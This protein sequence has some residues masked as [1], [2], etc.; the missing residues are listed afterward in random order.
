MAMHRSSS[1]AGSNPRRRAPP[2]AAPAPTAGAG[3]RGRP[4]A[5]HAPGA[6]RVRGQPQHSAALPGR[7][8]RWRHR[9]GARAVDRRTRVGRR[10]PA[11]AAELWAGAGTGPSPQVWA[12]ARACAT[13]ALLACCRRTRCWRVVLQCAAHSR[14]RL[15]ISG[16]PRRTQCTTLL[17]TCSAPTRRPTAPTSPP[18]PTA[19][20]CCWCAPCLACRCFARLPDPAAGA[21]RCMPLH[22]RYSCPHAHVQPYPPAGPPARP[23]PSLRPAGR[24]GAARRRVCARAPVHDPALPLRRRAHHERAGAPLWGAG[25][26]A[27][28]VFKARLVAAVAAAS[29]AAERRCCRRRS[30]QMPEHGRDPDDIMRILEDWTDIQLE[31]FFK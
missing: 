12:R 19:W 14:L 11:P 3:G 28:G 21:A 23:P 26:G 30:A 22:A 18:T 31:G 4:G 6:A 9:R 24:R 7:V 15:R 2:L 8:R 13:A 27:G 1:T 16:Q 17:T 10:Q 20:P 25:R 29:A 5:V